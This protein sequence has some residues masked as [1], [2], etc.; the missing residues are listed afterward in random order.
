MVLSNTLVLECH[1]AF[2][3]NKV[4]SFE[5]HGIYKLRFTFNFFLRVFTKKNE[6]YSYQTVVAF[7]A[8]IFVMAVAGFMAKA[9]A[10]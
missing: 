7:V 4:Y 10:E 3:C 5:Y 6:L 2:G 9:I 1:K 8:V